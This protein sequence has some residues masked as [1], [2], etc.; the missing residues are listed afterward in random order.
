MKFEDL[1]LPKHYPK[2]PIKLQTTEFNQACLL[3]GL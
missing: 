1:Y 3:E 2:E